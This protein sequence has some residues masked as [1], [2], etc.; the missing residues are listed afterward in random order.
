MNDQHL[1]QWFRQMAVLLHCGIP[2]IRALEACAKQTSDG[3]LRAATAILLAELRIGQRVSEAMR[4]AGLPFSPLHCGAVEVGEK[5][6]DLSLV[7]DRLADH[8]EETSRVRRRLISALTYPALVVGF[9]LS[10]LY[11]LV[12]FL[13]PVLSDVARQLGQEPTGV[14]RLLLGLGRLFETES[15]MLLLAAILFLATRS[16]S[17]FL[18]G[19][20]RRRTER[21]LLRVPLVGKMFRLSILIRICGTLEMMI[22]AGLPLTESLTLTARCCGSQEYAL[23]V[24]LPGV[25]RVRRGES[26]RSSLTSSA[27]PPSFAGM[28]LAGEESGRLEE[29]FGHLSRLY[30]L[31][32]VT[33]IDTFL[34]ALEPISIAVVGAVVLSVLLV[35]FVPLS[36]LVTIV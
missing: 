31:E 11:L 21:A 15:L 9:S 6:G 35:V 1:L 8:T 36:R 16:L 4:T 2:T 26:I 34:A 3:K 29:S 32:L 22:G 30:E 28:I 23:G 5:Q 20:H 27:F 13:A 25:E 17:G 7:F 33:S 10:C 19:K 14:S 12:R 24:L 18:W